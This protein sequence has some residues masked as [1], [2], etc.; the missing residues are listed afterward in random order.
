MPNFMMQMYL[1]SGVANIL[2]SP[3]Q[4]AQ[5]GS[6]SRAAVK[7]PKATRYFNNL[8]ALQNFKS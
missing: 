4:N 6:R 8:F 5:W 1:G 2:G 3:P 7:P